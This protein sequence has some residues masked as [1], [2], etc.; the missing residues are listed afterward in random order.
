MCVSN[1]EDRNP[2]RSSQRD[3]WKCGL[4]LSCCFGLEGCCF[5]EGHVQKVV[6]MPLPEFPTFHTETL[7]TKKWNRTE[8]GE[9]KNRNKVPL[10]LRCGALFTILH[11]RNCR[12]INVR[13]VPGEGALLI[14]LRLAICTTPTEHDERTR[15]QTLVSWPADGA[16]FP[17]PAV[18]PKADSC[19][20][21]T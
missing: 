11:S 16:A 15:V 17:W 13:N 21:P 6:A 9:R 7:G 14:R 8:F 2:W 1:F 12:K 20:H 10:P 19:I 3:H 4:V 5:K 18:M